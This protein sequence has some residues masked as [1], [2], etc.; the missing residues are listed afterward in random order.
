MVDYLKVSELDAITSAQGTDLMDISKDNGGSGYISKKI[1]VG[2][3][4]ASLP[5][6]SGQ[7]SFWMDG[8]QNLPALGDKNWIKMPYAGTFTGWYIDGDTTGSVVVTVKKSSSFPTFIDISGSE[9]PTLSSQQSNADTNLTTWTT[10]FSQG[11]Y[12]RVSVDSISG[13]TK[14][15][16][17]MYTKRS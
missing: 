16:V 13:L 6:A 5:S 12:I 9:K 1:T 15:L 10:A 17:T 2:E 14:V 11:D 3:F 4:A 7:V 8:G